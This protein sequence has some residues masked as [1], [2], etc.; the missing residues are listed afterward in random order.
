[1]NDNIFDCRNFR[2]IQLSSSNIMEA[3][4]KLEWNMRPDNI[5]DL[6]IAVEHLDRYCV[7]LWP[8]EWERWE[9]RSSKI[10]FFPPS[11]K[12][13]F[14][15]WKLMRV[16]KREFAWDFSQLSC[17]GR[18]QVRTTWE[19]KARICM[20]IFSSFVSW[21]NENNSCTR[22]HESCQEFS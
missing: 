1:M 6:N 4:I 18:T 14:P 3:P 10:I 9:L 15:G 17:L 20:V 21:P 13:K 5:E 2:D 8:E 12:V 16:E 7:Q 19:L 11:Q 22:V